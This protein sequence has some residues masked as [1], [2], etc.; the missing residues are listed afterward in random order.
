LRPV[1]VSGWSKK[2]WKTWRNLQGSRVPGKK[3]EGIHKRVE[4]FEKSWKEF[5]KSVLPAG[6]SVRE[7]GN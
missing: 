6:K 3:L 2:P 5:A 4:L 7:N 1:R